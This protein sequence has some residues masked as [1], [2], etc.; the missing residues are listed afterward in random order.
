MGKSNL[1]YV[2]FVSHLKKQ[3][4]ICSAVVHFQKIFG[5]KLKHSFRVILLSRHSAI[6]GLWKKFKISIIY[7][8][9]SHI[10]LIY[11]HV[12]LSINSGSLNFTG[13]KNYISKTKK[14]DEEIAQNDPYYNFVKN[15]KL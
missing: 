2:L 9:I 13:L 6:L 15:S 8:I 4:F 7:I 11:K 14:L 5:H 10:L 1:H 3:Q 12:Y